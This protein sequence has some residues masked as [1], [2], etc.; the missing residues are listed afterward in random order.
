MYVPYICSAV[1]AH[2]YII[3]LWTLRGGRKKSSPF[4][5]SVPTFKFRDR[6]T[7]ISR[8]VPYRTYRSSF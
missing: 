6:H 5:S 1:C 4:L 3:I 7:S 8:Y 2:T